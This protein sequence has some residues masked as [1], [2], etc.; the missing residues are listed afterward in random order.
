MS[1]P[2]ATAAMTLPEEAACTLNVGSV[3]LTSVED[4]VQFT[5]RYTILLSEHAMVEFV[6]STSMFQQ[7]STT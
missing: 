4:A 7:N 6:Q 2:S 5:T 1:V 3:Q